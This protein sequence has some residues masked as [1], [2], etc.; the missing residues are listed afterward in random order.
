MLIV[1]DASVLVVA[2]QRLGHEAVRL[3]RWLVDL[4]DGQELQILQN[5]TQLEVMSALRRLVLNGSVVESE[6]R[7]A[8]VKFM[9][10]PARR[11]QVTQPMAI[12]I[13]ELRNNL[14]PYDAAYVALTERLQSEEKVDVA[15]ATADVRLANAPGLSCDIRLFESD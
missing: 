15:L 5:L 3:R 4:S 7:D 9:E 1:A 8:I 6:A 13:W 12:R 2:L 10:L 11:L 14:T